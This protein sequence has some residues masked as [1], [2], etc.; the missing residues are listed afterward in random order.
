MSSGRTC[1]FRW[2]R[3][4]NHTRNTGGLRFDD[5]EAQAL[6]ARREDENVD[7][8]LQDLRNIGPG[9][10]E[11]GA[12]ADTEVH[13]GLFDLQSERS[14]TNQ[15]QLRVRIA[16]HH[17]GRDGEQQFVILLLDESPD[18]TDDQRLRAQSDGRAEPDVDGLKEWSEVDAAAQDRRVRLLPP[19][20]SEQGR[21][22]LPAH[23]DAVGGMTAD[24]APHGPG[25]RR[26]RTAREPGLKVEMAVNDPC[27]DLV[28]TREKARH[29]AEV[30]KVRVDDVVTATIERGANAAKVRR[31]T[32]QA[33]ASE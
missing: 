25:I 14:F 5:G 3:V 16:P 15:Q 31:A 11:N 12:V 10:G 9:P 30:L 33:S 18:M 13:A 4:G 22:R 27:G 2:H 7:G 28:S 29:T 8:S 24:E 23:R 6:V 1:D 32:D 21:R 20:T 19:V 17:L 26:F